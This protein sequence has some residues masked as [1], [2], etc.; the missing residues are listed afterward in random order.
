MITF[1]V[2]GL[3][4]V[5]PRAADTTATVCTLF[6]LI[7]HFQKFLCSYLF[8]SF[9]SYWS[10]WYLYFFNAFST[11]RIPLTWYPL[12]PQYSEKNFLTQWSYL[13]KCMVCEQSQSQWNCVNERLCVELVD[14]ELLFDANLASSV[15]SISATG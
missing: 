15:A 4:G 12:I 11:K 10:I 8:P 2:V 7:F 9:F 13:Q 3:K 6:L 1:R 5:Q 14:I